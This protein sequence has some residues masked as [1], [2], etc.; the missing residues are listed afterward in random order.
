MTRDIA[1]RIVAD[2]AVCHGAPCIRGTRVMVSV[3]LDCLADGMTHDQIVAEFQGLTDD[4]IAA[5]LAYAARV[6]QSDEEYAL[7]AQAG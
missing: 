2:P 6:M 5:A 4:D 3:L 7:E 1:P